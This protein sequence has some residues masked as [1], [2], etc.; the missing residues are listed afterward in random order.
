MDVNIILENEQSVIEITDEIYQVIENVVNKALECEKF[1]KDCMVSVTVVDNNQIHQLNNEFR[2]IDR[3]TDVLS[4]PVLEFED[5]KIIENHGDCFEGKL[6]LGDVILS[7]EKAKEQSIEY[8]HSLQREIGFLVCHSIL[9]L[10]GY[11]H[12]TEEDR[13]VMRQKEEASLELLGLTR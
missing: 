6:I 2:G 5:G 9:H 1:N 12:E 7:A 10:L 11:D 13:A 4:F 3:P 8:G